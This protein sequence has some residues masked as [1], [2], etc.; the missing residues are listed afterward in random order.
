MRKKMKPGREDEAG[1]D[2]DDDEDAAG[3]EMRELL[4]RGAD[5]GAVL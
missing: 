1:F 2:D 4:R 3:E 5:A